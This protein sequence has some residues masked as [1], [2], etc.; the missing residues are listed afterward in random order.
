VSIPFGSCTFATHYFTF[1]LGSKNKLATFYTL[2][3][4]ARVIR[5]WNS[6]NGRV[7]TSDDVQLLLDGDIRQQ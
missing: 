7:V 5:K 3:K 6:V 4:H 2:Y 1:N